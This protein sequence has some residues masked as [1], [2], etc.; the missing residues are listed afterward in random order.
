M[1][2]RR[3]AAHL[4]LLAVPLVGCG[5]QHSGDTAGVGAAG[6][7]DGGGNEPAVLVCASDQISCNVT[8]LKV[9]DS[10]SGCTVLSMPGSWYGFS[11]NVGIDSFAVDDSYLYWPEPE[12]NAIA[13]VAKVGGATEL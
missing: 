5:S 8:C 10:S 4:L 6:N 11:T 7:S 13:R 3:L 1:Q 9:G 12:A 2:I